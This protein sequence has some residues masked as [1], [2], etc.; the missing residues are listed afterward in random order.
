MTAPTDAPT[1]STTNTTALAA[2]EGTERHA[3]RELALTGACRFRASEHGWTLVCR[4]REDI[5]QAAEDALDALTAAGWT[6]TPL[7]G[8]GTVL[9]SPGPLRDTT[10]PHLVTRADTQQAFAALAARVRRLPPPVLDALWALVRAA[11]TT[12][13]LEG[14][15]MR[16]AY[17][18]R[19]LAR[20]RRTRR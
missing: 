13:R 10:G 16:H 4:G 12:H 2:P 11:D 20:R 17:R 1:T 14:A 15:A 8:T 9:T 5:P 18:A 3:L 19:Q 7:P 6:E